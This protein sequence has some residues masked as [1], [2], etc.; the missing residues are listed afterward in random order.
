MRLE[1]ERAGDPAS[2]PDRARH[3]DPSEYLRMTVWRAR[4]RDLAGSVPHVHDQRQ[5]L[6]LPVEHPDVRRDE[7]DVDLGVL[8]EPDVD[9]FVDVLQALIAE[10]AVEGADAAGA[11]AGAD[12]FALPR[13]L[14]DAQFGPKLDL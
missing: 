1:G 8:V 6:E 5:V 7:L 14:L 11:G 9:G 4:V 10:L 12:G 3:P 2:P 13:V